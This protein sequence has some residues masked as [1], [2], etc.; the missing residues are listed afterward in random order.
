MLRDC[1]PTHP[2]MRE[3]RSA[4]LAAFETATRGI[5]TSAALLDLLQTI[6]QNARVQSGGGSRGVARGRDL[7]NVSRRGRQHCASSRQAAR[8]RPVRSPGCP[9][10]GRGGPPGPD[11]CPRS[12][13]A[14]ARRKSELRVL[15]FDDLLVGARQL[16]DG[17]P[18]GGP[19]NRCADSAAAGRRV[20]GH[21]SAAGRT[22]QGAVRRGAGRRQVVFRG[23]LQAIDLSFSRGQS[24][25][26]PPTCEAH[27]R[28]PDSNRL[29]LQLPQPAGD[30][31]SSST[32]CSGTTW[33]SDY[34]PLRAAPP[35]SHV[36]SRPSSFCG[37]PRRRTSRESAD[38]MRGARPSGSPGAFA[39]CSTTASRWCGTRPRLPAIGPRARP[40]RLGDIAIL[41]RALTDVELYEAAL[42]KYEIDYYL[43]GGH[44]FYAQQEIYDLLNLLRALQQSGRRGEP[45]RRAAQPVLLAGRRNALLAGPASRRRRRRTVCG[46]QCPAEAIGAEQQRQVAFARA[47]RSASCGPAR[48]GCGS[49]N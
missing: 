12:A 9:P 6:R 16:L 46:R 13:P 17:P 1:E 45:G 19:A 28:S 36:R 8:R 35:A 14:Y 48:I 27:A 43:V 24:A 47:D 26:V 21:R 40:A 39:Q 25:R 22:G 49:A 7:R 4:L 23:R 5:T 3:R 38:E 37:R 33:A 2:R 32:P 11:D 31:A 42:R 41:F 15:D 10:G 44:A 20:S 18:R 29:S 30:L 34:E